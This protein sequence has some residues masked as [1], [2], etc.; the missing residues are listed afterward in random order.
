MLTGRDRHVEGACRQP[1]EAVEGA[2][3]R[4]VEDGVARYRGGPLGL[5]LWNDVSGGRSHGDSSSAP[6]VG[7]SWHKAPLPVFSTSIL[8]LGTRSRAIR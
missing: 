7:S 2:V 5:V 3:G 1:G 8:S 6:A 4:R